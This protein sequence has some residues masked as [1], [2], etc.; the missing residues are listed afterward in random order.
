MRAAF[1][2]AL[3]IL[4]AGC[5]GGD[6]PVESASVA[7]P[8]APAPEAAT[9]SNATESVADE[10]AVAPKP[11][12]VSYTGTAPAGACVFPAQAC[13]W[14]G[15]SEDYHAIAYQGRATHLA[16]Q[17]TYADQAPGM[18][19]YISLCRGEGTDETT[20]TCDDY[21]TAPSPM[22]LEFDLRGD[23]AGA[24]YGLSVGSVSDAVGSTGAAMLFGPA[25][26]AV[27][28]TLTVLPS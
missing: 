15:G 16:I 21:Q 7:T 9:A 3:A 2:L 20:V 1:A 12:S 4:A 6:A 14:T 25:N 24:S 11:V 27:E 26:F 19:F 22:M 8:T 23:P 28:G 18:T 13:Q 17:V 5:L 10:S